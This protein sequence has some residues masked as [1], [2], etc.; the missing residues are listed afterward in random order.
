MAV[1]AKPLVNAKFAASSANTEYTTP[2]STR[3]IIDKCTATNTTGGAVTLSVWLIPS[4]GSRGN[5][6]KIID[7]VSV[8]ANTCKDFSELQN[9]I[10]GTGDTIDILAGSAT[11][12]NIKVSGREIT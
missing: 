11:S 12:I 1:V 10:L 2:A 6:N 5:S 8:P 9:Q 4:G 3:T 7:A